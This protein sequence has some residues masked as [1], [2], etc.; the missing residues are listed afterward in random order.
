[1]RD[2]SR[3]RSGVEPTPETHYAQGADGGQ[4]AY[5]VAGSGPTVMLCV[6][7]MLSIDLMWDEP[8]FAQVFDRLSSFCRHAWFDTRGSGSSGS[9][10][11]GE[12]RT[13]ASVTDDMVTVLDAL[14]EQSVIVFGWTSPPAL[15]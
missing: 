2:C 3:E 15:L 12:P 7:V 4:V 14:G 5:Q 11:S 8:I 6:N 9:L 13:I 1:M 10:P